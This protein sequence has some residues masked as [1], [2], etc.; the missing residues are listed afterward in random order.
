MGIINGYLEVG[1]SDCVSIG[2]SYLLPRPD[3]IRIF[4]P[5][6]RVLSKGKVIPQLNEFRNFLT[7]G[8]AFQCQTFSI[9]KSK[10]VEE[11]SEV[12]RQL[13][14]N[15]S[16][17]ISQDDHPLCHYLNFSNMGSQRTNL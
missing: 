13:L 6:H 17:S 4:W 5:G 14:K 7:F 2:Y 11:H 8:I 9:A 10:H 1:V 16:L 15:K 12:F 3:I